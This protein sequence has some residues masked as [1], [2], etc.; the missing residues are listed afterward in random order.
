MS[1]RC[2]IILIM[3]SAGLRAQNVSIIDS[4]HYSNVFGE[5][6]NFRIFLP[7]GYNENPGNKYPVI[8]FFHGWSQRYFGDGGEAYANFD[9][10]DD[11]NGDNIA[12]FV[13]KNDVIV[14][15]W[16]GYNRSAEEEYYKRPYNVTPVETFRQFPIYFPELVNYIDDHFQTL[17]D[18]QHR[19]VSGLSM[20]GFMSFWIS[21]KYPHL[22]SAAGS[23]CGSPEFEVGPKSFPVEYRHIDM[24]KNFSGVD[25]RLHHGDKD[26]IRAYHQDMNRIWPQLMNNY[27]YKIYDGEHSTTGLGEMFSSFMKTFLDPPEKPEKWDHIEV[28]PEFSVWDFHVSSDR[29]IPGFTILENVDER[30]FRC[31]VREYVPDGEIFG[32]VN[33]TVTTAPIYEKNQVF[34]INDYDPVNLKTSQREVRSDHEGRLTI[35]IKGNIHEIGINKKTDKPNISLASNKIDLPWAI[36]GKEIKLN[37]TIFNKGATAAKNVNGKL[38][39]TKNNVKI[40][41][42]TSSF[43]DVA[44]NGTAKGKSTFNFKV[45]DTVEIIKLQL[46]FQDAGRNEWIQFIDIPVK[47]DVAEI[48]DFEIADGKVFTV[49]SGGTDI[50]TGLLGNGNGDGT[51][52]PGE[53]IILLVRDNGKLWRT[54]LTFNDKFLNPF[55]I[56]ERRSDSWTN[57]DHVGASAKYDVPLISSTCPQNQPIQFFAEYW[58]PR[59]PF[60]IMKQGVIKISVKGEDKTAPVILSAHVQGNNIIEAR[61]F[62]GSKIRNARAL[63]ISKDDPEKSWNWC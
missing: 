46:N 54:D 2:L 35:K 38:S 19:A 29:A 61:I 30:G 6:R 40:L 47:N 58:V 7:P 13:S 3:L 20:G 60:H 25:V 43:G 51:P 45:E 23:F 31:S 12:N 55:G 34:T 24:Y 57:F 27:Q 39:A 62:D 41:Q 16:D 28:Y 36:R 11:N 26:F 42:N 44:V 50:W 53:S 48:T 10:G 17:S 18:R 59:Y 37:V 32:H 21:A 15:K 8:Y 22:V 5:I 56:N 4:R 9:K 52:N 33:L 14:V 49:A 1:F 63:I